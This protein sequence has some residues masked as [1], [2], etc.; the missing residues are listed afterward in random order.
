MPLV[1]TTDYLLQR[2]VVQSPF[3]KRKGN[4]QTA[5]VSDGYLPTLT[6]FDARRFGT[7]DEDPGKT[8]GVAHTEVK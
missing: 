5:V 6:H 4:L 3:P 7:D 8:G 1:G 2:K